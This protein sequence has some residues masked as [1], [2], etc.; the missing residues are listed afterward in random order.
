[1]KPNILFLLIDSFR[2]DKCVGN[3]KTSLTPNIDNLIKNNVYFSQAICSAPVTSPS[4][5]SIFTSQYPFESTIED[6]NHYKI[7]PN[8]PTYI[9]DFIKLG[10]S[11]FGIT[12]ELSSYMGLKKNI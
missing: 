11:P 6:E 12:P 2:A 3:T 8:I 9:D 7:N 10:Y 5:S 4:I 1:M